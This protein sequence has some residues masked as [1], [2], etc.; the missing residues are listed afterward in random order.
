MAASGTSTWISSWWTSTS[1]WPTTAARRVATRSGASARPG[2]ARTGA[3]APRGGTASSASA[4]WASGGVTAARG[5]S[6]YVA[7]TGTATWCSTPCCA[8]SSSPGP[9]G[10][11]S[12]RGLPGDFCYT[13][14]S[15]RAPTPPC[16]LTADT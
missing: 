14:S 10:S 1:L 3:P 5:W 8:P 12:A 15:V 2:P 11:P 7:L 16:G 6:L 13:C 9:W 4:P